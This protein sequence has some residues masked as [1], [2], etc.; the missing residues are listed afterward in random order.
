MAC[1]NLNRS[2]KTGL[3]SLKQHQIPTDRLIVET[4]VHSR[5]CLCADHSSRYIMTR[6]SY[7]EAWCVLQTSCNYGK[8]QWHLQACIPVLG[9]QIAEVDQGHFVHAG[10]ALVH[11]SRAPIYV[12][13]W[14]IKRAAVCH[15]DLKAA[16]SRSGEVIKAHHVV[17][18][19]SGGC[20]GCLDGELV[21]VRLVA[22]LHL[23]ATQ[24][25]D[26]LSR[27]C[28]RMTLV[29]C[30]RQCHAH[31]QERGR[32]SNKAHSMLHYGPDFLSREYWAFNTTSASACWDVVSWM[33]LSGDSKRGSRH[34]QQRSP[35]H[36][37]SLCQRC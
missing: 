8:I 21:R 20:D 26:E 35:Q 25:V 9:C 32:M 24:D 12:V 31:L 6:V 30:G 36:K 34:S 13:Y 37:C 14:A 10:L 18:V 16:K 29:S 3:G 7:Q 27:D 1:P 28:L 17:V 22:Q 5:K 11:A 4:E 15:T 19:P 2:A 33:E 23:A